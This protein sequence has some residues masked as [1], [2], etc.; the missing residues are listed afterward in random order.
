MMTVVDDNDNGV[1][2]YDPV[3]GEGETTMWFDSGSMQ[4][5]DAHFVGFDIQASAIITDKDRLDL[6]VS[7]VLKEFVDLVFDWEPI[8]NSLGLPDLDYIG[9][10][11]PQA[12]KWK[13]TASYNHNF[14]LGNG[15]ILAFNLEANYT[16]EYSIN[17]QAYRTSIN[18]DLETGDYN[19]RIV[20]KADVRW[21]EA[22]YIGDASLVYT[23][24]DG[25]WSSSG[26]V[27]NFQNYAVKRFMD[28]MGN[29]FLNNPRTYGAVLTVSY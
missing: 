1:W 25:K 19:A 29:M 8:T 3:T 11:M 14:H 27:K 28:G 2:D 7:Y 20:S 12:P 18:I 16:S 17:W 23:S 9:M 10:Q 24:P 13:G 4:Q 15:G 6:S 21:Q 22:Y 26:Y 5:G